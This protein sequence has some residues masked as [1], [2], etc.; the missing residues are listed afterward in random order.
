MVN[1]GL[2]L[3]LPAS[4]SA[5]LSVTITVGNFVDTVVGRNGE[6]IMALSENLTMNVAYI[7][8][9]FVYVGSSQGWVMS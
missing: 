2:T 1:P 7:S 9:R 3:T 8:I 6:K 5:G 4:P